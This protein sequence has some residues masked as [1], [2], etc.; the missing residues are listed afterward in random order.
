MRD[1]E[2]EK[3][4]RKGSNSDAQQRGNGLVQVTGG[5]DRVET[6][7]SICHLTHRLYSS[8]ISS[9]SWCRE[10]VHKTMPLSGTS[11]SV[12]GGLVKSLPLP[13]KALYL[14]FR[15]CSGRLSHGQ[16]V[17]KGILSLVGVLCSVGRLWQYPRGEA[18]GGGRGGVQQ[19]RESMVAA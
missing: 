10:G 2:R 12:I 4:R 18:R 16:K 14:L 7:F 1:R 15:W 3:V 13:P 6:S 17:P 19:V 11:L 5:G 9:I 8:L